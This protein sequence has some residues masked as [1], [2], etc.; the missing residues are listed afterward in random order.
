MAERTD[1]RTRSRS[2]SRTDRR[3]ETGFD[4]LVSNDPGE[5]SDTV[6]PASASSV[7]TDAERSRLRDRLSS[8]G[9][10]LFSPRVFVLSLVLV[11]TGAL[12]GGAVPL[13]GSL[14]GLV[15]VFVA[16]FVLGLGVGGRHYL[17][18]GLAG[19]T[20]GG[21]SFLVRNLLF[22]VAAG[23]GTEIAAFGAGA[24]LLVVVVGYYFGRDLRSGLTREID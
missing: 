15:G 21:F 6:A 10:N 8:P 23:R 19:A 16:G 4:D 9:K 17:E 2:D 18:L 14:T 20:A 5:R 13:F 3:S 11:L 22:S 24:G 12:L 1:E 7:P